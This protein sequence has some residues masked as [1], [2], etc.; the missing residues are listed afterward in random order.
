MVK[1]LL[2]VVLASALAAFAQG[3]PAGSHPGGPPSGSPGMSGSPMGRGDTMSDNR[4]SMGR[5]GSDAHGMSQTQQPLKESQINGG[6]FRMLESKTGM[7]SAQLQD[8]YRSSGARNFGEFVSAVV[9][10][11][12]LNLDTS[13]VLEGL[14]TDSL[15][16][17]LQNLGVDKKK[18]N[19]EIKKARQEVRASEKS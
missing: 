10:A 4:G 14:K 18:A 11:K 1:G 19:E 8:L 13:K 16:K 7:T 5:Q 6:A 12:N 3:R 9:V 17:T 2:V 15:G